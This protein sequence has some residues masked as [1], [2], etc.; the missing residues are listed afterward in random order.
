MIHMP[1][2]TKKVL[3]LWGIF[4]LI[5]KYVNI[6]SIIGAP[7]VALITPL[8]GSFLSLNQTCVALA[9]ITIF[10]LSLS[11]LFF[12]KLPI[13]LGLPSAM[14]AFSWSTSK[15]LSKSIYIKIIDFSIHVVLPITCISL[16]VTH[17]VGH[18]AWHY[19]MYWLIPIALWM[20]RISFPWTNSFIFALQ[21][22]FI[23][24]A[25]GSIMWLFF[26]P[27]TSIYWLGLIPIVAAER[28]VMA[29]MMTMLYESISW[30]LQYKKSYQLHRSCSEQ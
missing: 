30:L 23:A 29:G 10:K 15:T 21:S 28:L 1:T 9:V 22:T 11:K 24:H 3:G 4:F 5:R 14:A 12:I 20:I 18:D 13:T 16:F 27:T 7:H 2:K 6:S 17:S 26:M 8:L 19:A 25:I